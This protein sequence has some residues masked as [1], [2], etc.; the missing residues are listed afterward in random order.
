MT[1][2]LEGGWV[3]S[4]TPHPHLT[5]GKDLVP[6]VLEAG[7]APG[8]V[9]IGAENLAPPGFNSRTFQPV[10]NIGPHSEPEWSCCVAQV[11][12]ANTLVFDGSLFYSVVKWLLVQEVY[13]IA[14]SQLGVSSYVLFGSAVM[15]V[16][17]I[18][19]CRIPYFKKKKKNV[20]TCKIVA[21]SQ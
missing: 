15:K 1:T 7:W 9:W 13:F 4:S 12:L 20:T 11:I 5:P 10:V 21:V 8:P 16:D 2:A 17:G 19:I 3:V 14:F 18:N 6:I